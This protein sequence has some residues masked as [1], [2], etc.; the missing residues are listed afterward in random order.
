MVDN[1]GEPTHDDDNDYGESLMMDVDGDSQL[2]ASND[3]LNNT[4]SILFNKFKIL[5]MLISLFIVMTMVDK[6]VKLMNPYCQM[7]DK[8]VVDAKLLNQLDACS[9]V[10]KWPFPLL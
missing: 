3:W 6:Q 4:C 7:V 2:I 10:N 9:W 1:D 5:T 8:L